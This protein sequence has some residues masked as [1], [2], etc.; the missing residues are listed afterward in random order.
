MTKIWIKAAGVRAVKTMAQ[1]ALAVLGTG[2][3]GLMEVDWLNIVSITLMA[4]ICSVLT[5]I[6]GL[7]E[8]KDEVTE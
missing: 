6:A 3:I 5:S 7:P 1:A 2:T 8:V 4:G